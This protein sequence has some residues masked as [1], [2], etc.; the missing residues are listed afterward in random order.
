MPFGLWCYRID[1]HRLLLGGALTDGGSVIKWLEDSFGI[2]AGCDHSPPPPTH[3]YLLPL[4][5]TLCFAGWP[6]LLVV[7]PPQAL[8]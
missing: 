6:V 5:L 2:T 7:L 8:D 3:A 4:P 1:R